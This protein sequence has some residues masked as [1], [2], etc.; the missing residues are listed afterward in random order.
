[1]IERGSNQVEFG[2]GRSSSSVRRRSMWE[3]MAL[4]GNLCGDR[5]R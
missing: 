4:L 2:H 5:V 1:M 3:G